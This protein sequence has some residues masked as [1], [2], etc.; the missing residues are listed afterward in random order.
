MGLGS[1]SK[2]LLRSSK[3][4]KDDLGLGRSS[5]RLHR[6]PRRSDISPHLEEE[7]GRGH[8]HDLS[9]KH[10]THS[11]ALHNRRVSDIL[12]N[13]EI[14]DDIGRG[15][16]QKGS[17]RGLEKHSSGKGK[18]GLLSYRDLK[19][20]YGKRRHRSSGC[21]GSSPVSSCG[22]WDDRHLHH[23]MG[24][25]GLSSSLLLNNHHHHALLASA[26]ENNSQIV[27]NAQEAA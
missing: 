18:S 27:K 19:T 4:D 21:C 10:R 13:E 12:A 16:T 6:T 23:G 15:G 5:S 17:K 2:K 26:K 24:C 22:E 3:L 25:G 8:L 20:N 1:S 11:A 7:L 9:A 14:I